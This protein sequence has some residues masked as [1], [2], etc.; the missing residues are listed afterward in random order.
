MIRTIITNEILTMLM[1]VERAKANFGVVKVPMSW[2]NRLRKS[3]K[4]KSSYASNHIEGNPLTEEQSD[5]V[6]DDPSRRHYL[7][8]EQEI[9]NYFD[10]LSFL[11]SERKKGTP[12]TKSFVLAVQKIVVKGESAEKTG[13]RGPMPPGVLFAVYDDATGVPEYI[14]PEA[15]DL[16]SLLDELMTY[17]ATSDDHPILKAAIAHYQLVTIHPFEDG[18]GRTARLV[19]DY[20]LDLGGYG[21][22]K[23]G[24]L[25]EYFAY[26]IDAYYK[27]LQMGLPALYYDGRANPP[28]PEVWLSYFVHMMELHANRVL[29]LVSQQNGQQAAAGA[30]FLSLKERRFLEY[31]VRHRIK[32]FAP[33]ELAAPMHVTSRSIVNWCAALVRNGFLL[34]DT[35]GKRIRSYQVTELTRNGK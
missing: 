33:A 23:I 22:N 19:S 35:A 4:K 32:S 24:S 30:S 14:P 29:E 13:I 20:L 34:P 5:A 16:E 6:L 11:E 17:L 26:D 28:H 8:P 2:A 15:G 25:E 3:S 31:L 10:A 1:S 21:F 9:K 7:K 12:V 27:A 18:N